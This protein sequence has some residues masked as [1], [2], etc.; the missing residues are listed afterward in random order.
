M[1][2]QEIVRGVFKAYKAAGMT[3]AGIW[4]MLGNAMS[5][6]TLC[7]YR[8]QGDFSEGYQRSLVYT[9]Q[10]DSGV[11]SKADFVYRG[12]NG[13]G[14]G[15]YQWTLQSRKDGYYDEAKRRGC[16]IGD[17]QLAID[18]S[19]KEL[20]TDP[21][22][23][24][25][26]WVVLSSTNDITEAAD[27]VCRIYEN[28]QIKNYGERREAARSLRDKYAAGMD[29]DDEPEPPVEPEKPE[30]PDTDDEGIP[31]PKTWPP[32]PVDSHCSGWPEVWLVQSLLRCRGY[33]VLDDGIWGSVMTDKVKQFQTE[34]GLDADG[35]VGKNTYIKLGIDPAVFEGR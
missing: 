2:E 22:F 7:P 1:T 17:L 12:P 3:D 35:V 9:R 24:D 31:I 14:Y 5:E 11:I 23:R 26:V 8:L 16:S 10:V 25:N 18:Y 15:F 19:L 28:P 13:G 21:Y 32:R 27:V 30:E 4:G 6:S 20:K 33:N 29:S 34:N